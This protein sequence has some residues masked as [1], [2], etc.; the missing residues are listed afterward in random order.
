MCT[1]IATA[2]LRNTV[3]GES[4]ASHYRGAANQIA[5]LADTNAEQPVTTQ[6]V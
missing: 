3:R 1:P 2:S 5:A 6:E 4:R